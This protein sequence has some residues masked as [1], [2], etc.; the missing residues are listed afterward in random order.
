MI[1]NILFCLVLNNGWL[2]SNFQFCQLSSRA[3]VAPENWKTAVDFLSN[4]KWQCDPNLQTSFMELAFH[5]WCSGLRFQDLDE[6]RAQYATH[7]RKIISQALRCQPDNPI[8]PGDIF[9]HS[10]SNGKT[11]PSGV[12]CGGYPLIPPDS[13][14][15]FA[16]PLLQGR[17]D[18][19]REWATPFNPQ[20]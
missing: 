17:K 2:I 11:H 5:F 3:S 4:L 19:L 10:K 7:I 20:N 12:I 1:L 15:V 6:T 13:L 18:S 9:A 14:R 16:L 8:V